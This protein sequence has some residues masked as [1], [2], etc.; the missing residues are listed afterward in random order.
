MKSEHRHELKTNELADWLAHFPEWAKTNRNTLIGAAVVLVVAGGVYFWLFYQRGAAAA[1]TQIRLTNL[2]TQVPSQKGALARSLAQGGMQSD[3]LLA[4]ARDLQDFARGVGDDKMAALALIE[5]AEAIRAD[6]HYRS[7]DVS[8]AELSD[9][10]GQARN[11]Y[12]QALDRVGSDPL[13]AAK[14]HFGLGLCEEELGNFDAARQ[15][16]RDIVDNADY[17]GTTGRAA[18]E[19]RLAVMDDYR[20]PVVFK[21]A[22][23]PKASQPQIQVR[24]GDANAPIVIPVPNDVTVGPALPPETTETDDSIDADAGADEAETTDTTEVAEANQPAGN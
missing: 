20:G 8:Q 12:Q 23:K 18:A 9:Q 16:Y 22:P 6:L 10:I 17:E 4:V 1:Q 14:A 19:Y 13:L 3:V 7:G 11:S 24:P 5:R 21:P 2:V 15:I